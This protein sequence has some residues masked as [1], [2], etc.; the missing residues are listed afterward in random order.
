M[1]HA[2]P[3][4]AKSRNRVVSFQVKENRTRTR[5]LETA[6]PKLMPDPREVYPEDKQ[7]LAS[8]QSAVS[9]RV[10]QALRDD[11]DPMAS[12]SDIRSLL[13][14]PA[15]RAQEARIEE[16]LAI[17]EETDRSYQQIFK[18]LHARGDAL[19]ET[20]EI[21]KHE[22]GKTN[23]A[24]VNASAQHDQNLLQAS[25]ELGH[26]IK[27]LS[28]KFES[29]FQKLFGDLTSRIDSV[30]AKSANDSQALLNFVNNR[31]SDL[32]SAAFANDE[33]VSAKLEHR[34]AT[35]EAA[36]KAHR[37]NDLNSISDGL[38]DLSDRVTKLRMA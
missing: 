15:A 3:Q 10:L 38:A 29:D 22:V 14:G 8:P 36:L 11:A 7:P 20:T 17:M 27:E 30:A 1:Q 28:Q 31:M 25:R 34:I 5:N 16:L 23:E 19:T 4:T 37:I 24:V 6:A 32:E 26:S 35:V 2:T 13:V 21:I 9:A 33:H 12:L 18:N